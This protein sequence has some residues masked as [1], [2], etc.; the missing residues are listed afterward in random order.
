[1]IKFYR[2]CCLLATLILVPV[3]MLQAQSKTVTGTVRDENGLTMPGVN[4]LLKGTSSGTVTDSDGKYAI[5]V[6]G[7]DAIIVFSFV[8]YRTSEVIVGNRSIIDFQMM[9]DA[10]TL[11]ELVVTGYTAEQKKDI[12]GSVS[13]V[14]SK[15]LL[16]TPSSDLVTQLQGRAAGVTVSTPGQPGAASSIRIRGFTTFGNNA[17]LYIVDGVPTVNPGQLNPQDIESVQV[18]KDAASASIYGARAANGVILITTRS[19]K[20]GESKI[21]YQSFYGVQKLDEGRFPTLTNTQ[22]YA[23]YIW[24]IY[25][26]APPSGHRIFGD[27]ATPVIPTYLINNPQNTLLPSGGSEINPLESNPDLYSTLTSNPFT[28]ARTSAG[29]DWFRAITQTGAVQSHQITLTGGSDKNKFS[30]GLNYFDQKG[31]IIHSSYKRG[32]VRANTLFNIKDNFRV[33]ENL[34]IGYEYRTGAAIGD[35]RGEGGAWSMA[36][37]MVPYIPV[38]DLNGGFAGNGIGDSGNGSNPVADLTRRKDNR[39]FGYRIF[40]NSFAEVDFLKNFTARTSIGIDYDNDY[41]KFYQAQTYERAENLTTDRSTENYDY[42]QSWIWTNT[43][44]FNKDFSNHNIKVLVGS[45]ALKNSGRYLQYSREN[46]DLVDPDFVGP[47]TGQGTPSVSGNTNQQSPDTYRETLFSLFARVDYS[48]GEKYL[49]NATLRRDGSSKFAPGNQYATFPA[50]GIGWRISEEPFIKS[51]L[52]TDLKLRASWGQV[53]SMRNV[54]T[55]NQ[56]SIYSASPYDRYAIDG[57]NNGGAV[58]YR[59]SRLGNL[60]TRWE[61]AETTNIGIDASI[62]DGKKIDMS[63]DYFKTETKDLLVFR[64]ASLLEPTFFQPYINVGT[65]ENKGLDLKIGYRATLGKELELNTALT[66]THYTNE[67]TKLD[68]EGTG[69]FTRNDR[70]NRQNGQ[71]RTEAGHPMSSF[72]GYRIEGFY[73]NAE[74]I[75]NSP[76]YPNARVGGW[77]LKDLNGDDKIDENDKTYLGSPIPDFQMGL[78]I[79]LNYKNFDFAAFL[80]L[81]YGNEIYNFTK[82]WT[83]LRGFTGG[84]SRE[85]IRAAWTP[86]TAATATLPSLVPGDAVSASLVTNYYIESGSYLR[87]KN[88]QLGYNL[89]SGLTSKL[90]IDHLRIYIQ[91]QNLFTITNYTGA[92][93]D[94][95]IQNR[96]DDTIMG[97]DES[98]YPNARQFLVGVNVTF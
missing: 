34:Q 59:L 61:T 94:I 5:G 52:F 32:T 28:V 85:V 88:I 36:Y 16:A 7:D 46:Y 18:L 96:V 64:Q 57:S 51:G 12:I 53:G 77:K 24:D 73:D 65:M 42:D 74:E 62:L 97:I 4:I 25:N 40:G 76:A 33:G 13:V 54:P 47:D 20:P 37:R 92:D 84:V 17:P 70:S 89:P 2:K 90:R 27:G 3:A 23:D 66:F 14:S 68:A 56:Y 55:I 87:A 79:S 39:S 60:N 48:Y 81:N 80:F 11:S 69:V 21:S 22:E 44:R 91:A 19:G 30:V 29:T 50:F 6:P 98:G 93:P 86:E 75:A 82:F 78:N 58:G 10:Q 72:Y 26:G 9:P 15:D 35:P 67:V 63:I 95:N 31:V 38:Y 1:M 45:E 49:F 43:L 71:L 83:H 41:N 8:G